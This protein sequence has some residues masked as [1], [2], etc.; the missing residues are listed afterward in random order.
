MQILPEP[1][2]HTQRVFDREIHG[3]RCRVKGSRVRIRS[4]WSEN[5]V[6]VLGILVTFSKSKTARI[7]NHHYATKVGFKF[8]QNIAR[9]SKKLHNA[10]TIL[11]RVR[12]QGIC[13][14]RIRLGNLLSNQLLH[15]CDVF[16]TFAG[17]RTSLNRGNCHSN[18]PA[19]RWKIWGSKWHP[20][21]KLWRTLWRV[22]KRGF[23]LPKPWSK[24]PLHP[25]FYPLRNLASTPSTSYPQSRWWE[26]HQHQHQLR[27]I[28]TII[29]LPA[30]LST[31]VASSKMAYPRVGLLLKLLPLHNQHSHCTALQQPIS[32][33]MWNHPRNSTRVQFEPQSNKSDCTEI[34]NIHIYTCII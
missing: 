6:N 22:W 32:D 11:F 18:F 29:A 24:R 5:L 27:I 2:L 1:N 15:L 16:V 23:A 3:L 33:D 28:T 31:P 9:V 17:A 10:K 19:R 25:T 20:W 7:S 8:I 21:R 4:I 30:A 14:K 13:V 12:V 34:Q 26:K